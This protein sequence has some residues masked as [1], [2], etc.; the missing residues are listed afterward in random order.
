[1]R[2]KHSLL[3]CSLCFA[4][5]LFQA[6]A[7]GE[8]ERYSPQ[9]LKQERCSERDFYFARE[10]WNPSYPDADQDSSDCRSAQGTPAAVLTE[11]SQMTARGWTFTSTIDHPDCH[12]NAQG[13][14]SR[15]VGNLI[16]LG[17]PIQWEDDPNFPFCAILTCLSPDSLRGAVEAT[18]QTFSRSGAEY[19]IFRR[20]VDAF[21]VGGDGHALSLPRVPE[22]PAPD[23]RSLAGPQCR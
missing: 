1:M 5:V 14:Q 12:F 2:M 21:L 10:I 7:A 13:T 9:D 22:S 17:F 23:Q 15:P 20:R 4:S 19:P 6:C 8:A 18:G 16:T 11:E 3:S